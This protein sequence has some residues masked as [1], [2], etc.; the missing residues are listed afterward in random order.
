MSWFFIAFVTTDME[1]RCQLQRIQ[2]PPRPYKHK[3]QDPINGFW[4]PPMLYRAFAPDCR[5]LMFMLSVGPLK[6]PCMLPVVLL[7]TEVLVMSAVNQAVRRWRK[8]HPGG[9]CL[10][11]RT[12]APSGKCGHKDLRGNANR[13]RVGL[14]MPARNVLHAFAS[15]FP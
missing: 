9:R 6:Q 15:S 13:F 10:T 1:E 3:V 5:I 2:G 4:N 11:E 14:T 8:L 7:A 12:Q